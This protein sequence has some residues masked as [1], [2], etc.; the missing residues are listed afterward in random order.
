MKNNWLPDLYIKTYLFAEQAHR[1][2]LVPGTEMPYIVHVNF[3]AMEVIAALTVE[4]N[5]D[6]N[7]AVPCA[8]LHDVIED[9]TITFEEIKAEFGPV[10]AAGVLS[11]SKSEKLDKPIQLADS[12]A[13]VRQQPREIWMVKLADRITNFQPPPSFWTK[14]KIVHYRDDAH[15]IYDPLREASPVLAERLRNK[16]EGYQS[17]RSLRSN[18]QAKATLDLH[19][20]KQG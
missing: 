5:H 9:K 11:L 17:Q 16:I 12:L 13:R 4:P 18:K 15:L 8:L 20:I 19:H 10:V 1:G 6:E 7:L 3:V 2:Q 14:E